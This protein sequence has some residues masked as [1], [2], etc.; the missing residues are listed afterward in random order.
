[1]LNGIDVASW[2]GGIDLKQVPGDFVLIKVS[3]GRGYR[4][5]A[6]AAQ[7]ASAKQAGRL[8]GLYHFARVGDPSEQARYFV[9]TAKPYLPKAVLA[10]DWEN[11]GREKTIQ[12]GST[13][14]KRWLDEVERLSGKR[15]L[16]YMSL[17]VEHAY[18][19]RQVAAHHGLWVAQYNH[20]RPVEGYQPRKLYGQLKYWSRYTIFQYSSTGRLPG[21]RKDL[22]LNTFNGNRTSWERLA[23]SQTVISQPPT[24][25][26]QLEIYQRQRKAT[27][28]LR[29]RAAQ[30]TRSAI[31]GLLQAGER[32]FASR[33]T[34]NGQV[35]KGN[36]Q[37]FEVA[38]R[39]WVA[40]AYTQA[41]AEKTR[42]YVVKS[43]DTLSEIAVRLDTSVDELVVKNRLRDPDRIYSGQ[44][45][46]Y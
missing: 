17:A 34:K 33:L 27:A 19:W 37:W 23:Q 2:Q 25:A 28:P 22:D 40:A 26:Y 31:I 16:V 8:L 5:P 39:G 30:N 32:F 9:K 6:L 18:D 4:N 35:I 43:G 41:V 20:F 42:L 7:F 44:R 38:G 13:W 10:L 36:S 11:T 1:M 12:Q 15:A 14:V 45:L 29:I 46:T 24:A 21:W 3:E